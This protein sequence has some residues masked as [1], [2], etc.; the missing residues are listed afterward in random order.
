MS[1]LFGKDL[2]LDVNGGNTASFELTYGADDVEFIA[3][4]RVGIGNNGNVDR[5]GD[6][7]GVFDHLAHGQ[8][9]IVGIAVAR[10]RTGPGHVDG[11]ETRVRDQCCRDAVVCARRDGHAVLPQQVTQLR[12]FAHVGLHHAGRTTRQLFTE[13]FRH[14]PDN[15][16]ARALPQWPSYHPVHCVL[17]ACCLG[18]AAHDR[19]K[20]RGGPM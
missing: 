14:H 7:P 17:P 1:A 8:Q 4:A 3:V 20:G 5:T 16:C 13:D 12:G 15:R 2:I 6:A 9:P 11:R 10:R 18:I 19:R